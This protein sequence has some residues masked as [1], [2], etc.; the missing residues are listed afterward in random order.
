MP[1]SLTILPH[2]LDH[3][4]AQQHHSP[5]E[6]ENLCIACALCNARKGPNLSGIDPRTGLLTRLFHPRQDVWSEHFRY[7]NAV[8]LGLTDVGRTTVEVLGI[9][10]ADR[11]VTR[12]LLIEAGLFLVS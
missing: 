4:I 5:T 6:P 12:R 11:L 8:L 10:N 2:E 9:N 3:I 1:Q 7:E